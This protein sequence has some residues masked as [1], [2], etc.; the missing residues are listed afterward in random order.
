ML[1]LLCMNLLP[2]CIFAQAKWRPGAAP[3][4]GFLAGAA[5]PSG[6]ARATFLLSKDSWSAGVGAGMDFYRFRSVPIFLQGRK[7]FGKRKSKPFALASAGINLPAVKAEDGEV[8]IWNRQWDMIWWNP[9]PTDY[10]PGW[11]AELG[12][13]Y[14]F[15][16]RKQRGL[17]LSLNW[18]YKSIS[19]W[20][21]TD[22][23]A[24]ANSNQ[25]DRTT[26]T[27]FL[28]RMALRVGWKF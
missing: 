16:N 8:G 21:E 3:E 12:A 10:D 5:E 23:P 25:K 11:Y 14:G 2:F 13:G 9:V 1:L 24:I 22:A 26:T 17:T 27:Y 19:E 15:F 28:N 4:L 20:Y 7:S 6:D 18:V